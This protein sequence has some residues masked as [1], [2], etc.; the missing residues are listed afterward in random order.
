MKKLAALLTTSI[1]LLGHASGAI[2]AK[3]IY[4]E[5]DDFINEVFAG[6]TPDVKRLWIDNELKEKIRKILGHDLSQLRLRYWQH[7]QRTAWILE[8]TGKTEPITLGFV[9]NKGSIELARVLIFRESRGWEIRHPFFTDQYINATLT[10]E[11]DLNR[12]IDGISGATL[13]VAAFNRL[14]RL[15]L[16]LD[17]LSHARHRKQRLK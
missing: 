11:L 17:Q 8:E 12:H 16:L 14:A 5:P 7:Q 15:A 2:Q 3:N 9:I 10:T 1:L 13:S 4:Q 6:V